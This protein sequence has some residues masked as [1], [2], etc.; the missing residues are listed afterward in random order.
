MARENI[1]DVIKK[2]ILGEGFLAENTE[3]TDITEGEDTSD[4]D[5]LAEEE[6]QE[7]EIEEGRT[8]GR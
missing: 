7:E 1:E 2:V 8:S 5:T 6:L 3:D 4:E